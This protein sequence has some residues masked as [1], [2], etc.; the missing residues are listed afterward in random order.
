MTRRPLCRRDE[1]RN[2]C[3]VG[4][5]R[6]EGTKKNCGPLPQNLRPSARGGGRTAAHRT[7]Y[8]GGAADK[9]V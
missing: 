9:P 8:G 7:P 3:S 5:S 1:S 4:S 2:L 6:D